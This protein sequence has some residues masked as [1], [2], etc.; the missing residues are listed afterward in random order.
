M[1]TKKISVTKA[2]LKEQGKRILGK[3][4][5]TNGIIGLYGWGDPKKRLRFVVAKGEIDDWAI[6][7]EDMDNQQG[8]EE[9]LSMGNKL[10]G[11]KAIKELVKCSPEVMERY[12]L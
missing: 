11:E 9:V 8:Y 4:I 12:R 5:T 6:Y 7:V 3:G 10:F 2:M 1:K